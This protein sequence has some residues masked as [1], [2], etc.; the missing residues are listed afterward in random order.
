MKTIKDVITL[1]SVIY[2]KGNYSM[3]GISDNFDE[4]ID[5]CD[6]IRSEA[7]NVVSIIASEGYVN[8][9]NN[10]KKEY[11]VIGAITDYERAKDWIIKQK[12]LNLIS[13]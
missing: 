13:L 6:K 11:V 10:G 12:E 4:M 7:G 1:Y 8:I 2:L 5:L 9:D 3:L